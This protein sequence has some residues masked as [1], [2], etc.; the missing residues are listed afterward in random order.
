MYPET[1][2][3]FFKKDWIKDGSIA[4]LHSRDDHE[5]MPGWKRKL[6]FLAPLLNLINLALYWLYFA[7][8][9]K[10]VIAAQKASNST[11]PL[12][13]VFIAIELSVALP[14]FM[15]NLW[16]VTAVKQR[17]RP[18]L[19]LVGNDVPRVDVFITCCG[20]DDDLVL[21]TTRASCDL[22]YPQDKFRVIV[23]DDGKSDGLK[24][25]VHDL[26]ETYPNVYY[27]RRPKFPGVP[28][29]FKAGNLN[30]GL[31]EVHTM[32]G[33]AAPFMAALDA[34]MVGFVLEPLQHIH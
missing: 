14:I 34:D 23:L 17:K 4:Q 8:R 11:F 24:N 25:A 30:Y 9:I 7:L 29:H 15:N 1:P 10:Y 27:K 26:S 31:D 20:E 13:W 5:F 21:D 32:P 16:N 22:D 28:H 19:R 18:Q 12:A 3:T 6:F 2:T 33:G